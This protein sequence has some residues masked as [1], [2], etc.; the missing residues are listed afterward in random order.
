MTVENPITRRQGVRA[1]GVAG[2]AYIA[3]PPLLGGLL[4]SRPRRRPPQPRSS[5]RS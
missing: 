3:A 4:S 2:A 1:V 5:L